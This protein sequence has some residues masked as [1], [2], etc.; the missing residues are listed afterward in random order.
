MKKYQQRGR[1][2]RVKKTPIIAGG[3]WN[4]LQNK[5]AE[6]SEFSTKLIQEV[7]NDLFYGKR[8]P[9]ERPIRMLIPVPAK[10]DRAG[11]RKIRKSLNKMRNYD[12]KK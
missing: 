11:R 6:A 7:F 2:N 1:T 8:V 4:Q 5:P 9:V 12:Q 3:L 10:S